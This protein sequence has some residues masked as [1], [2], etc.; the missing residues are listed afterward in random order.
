MVNTV[1]SN[2]SLHYTAHLSPVA[3]MG[4][5][6]TGWR[7]RLV[8]TATYHLFCY[9]GLKTISDSHLVYFYMVG[10]LDQQHEECPYDDHAYI[11]CLLKPR[12]PLH[13]QPNS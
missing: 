7:Q 2:M 11:L 13:K 12:N 4:L 6:Y 9:N 10:W 8:M 5:I 1:V 3:I